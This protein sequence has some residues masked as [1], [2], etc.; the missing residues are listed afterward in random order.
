MS[1]DTESRARRDGSFLGASSCCHDLALSMGTFQ[2]LGALLSVLM[3][4]SPAAGTALGSSYN[5]L[6]AGISGRSG[7]LS[8]SFILILDPLDHRL[9]NSR[10]TLSNTLLIH[11]PSPGLGAIS[12]GKHFH[13]HGKPFSDSIF[14]LVLPHYIHN[15]RDFQITV[16]LH[17][18]TQQTFLKT[19]LDMGFCLD[20]LKTDKIGS[21]PYAQSVGK[22]S[23]N[24]I[25]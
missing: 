25:E 19:L 21:V 23:S 22:P 17:L 8:V 11:F 9:R 20:D 10:S 3:V 14:I 5:T 18:L 16:F 2:H 13:E 6:S 12:S 7:L 15:S 24:L 4:G 1:P